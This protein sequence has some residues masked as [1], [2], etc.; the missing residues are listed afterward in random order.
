MTT[1]KKCENCSFWEF[2]K[3]H[4]HASDG[5]G[6][7]HKVPHYNTYENMRK[8]YHDPDAFEVELAAVVDGSGY[9][10]ELRTLPDFYCCLYEEKHIRDQFV[11]DGMTEDER[12]WIG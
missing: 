4:D 8:K 1:E 6:V 2:N 10:A 12:G 7:C 9:I 11:D 3:C 5:Y